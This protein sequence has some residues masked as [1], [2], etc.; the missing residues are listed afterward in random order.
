M[1]WE[2]ENIK[3]SSASR[4]SEDFVCNYVQ[5]RPLRSIFLE[6][7]ETELG[8]YLFIFILYFT[9]KVPLRYNICTFRKS[10]PRERKIY[11]YIIYEIYD[12]YIYHISHIRKQNDNTMFTKVKSLWK[13]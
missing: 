6:L 11:T 8:L 12:I 4:F 10:W 1:A 7:G 9:K 5:K 2:N 13:A 3:C